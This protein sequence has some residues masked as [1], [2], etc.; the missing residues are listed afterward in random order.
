VAPKVLAL[1]AKDKSWQYKPLCQQSRVKIV[2]ELQEPL[3]SKWLHG[4]RNRLYFRENQI[5]MKVRRGPEVPKYQ[6][7]SVVLGF[8]RM[9]G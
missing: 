5:E 9:G 1:Y 4:E 2:S 7:H 8:L 3:F 6:R